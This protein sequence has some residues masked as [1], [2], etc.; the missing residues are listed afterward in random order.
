MKAL[1]QIWQNW[2]YQAR[3]IGS[4]QARA[5]ITLVYFTAL[6]PFGLLSRLFSDPLKIK[7]AHDRTDTAWLSRRTRDLDLDTAHRQG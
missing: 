3:F 5:L 1:R 6:L 2:V 4:F 7:P